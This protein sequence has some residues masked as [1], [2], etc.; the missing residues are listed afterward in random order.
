MTGE[1]TVALEQVFVQAISKAKPD[2]WMRAA[3]ALGISLAECQRALS[4]D[5]W[6]ARDIGRFGN[7]WART[8]STGVPNR[9]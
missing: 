7:N 1:S 9:D 3:S 5:G 2:E 6:N 4:T 8:I